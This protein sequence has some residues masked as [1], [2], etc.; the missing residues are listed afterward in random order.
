MRIW[1]DFVYSIQTP[2]VR[3]VVLYCSCLT[4][5]IQ[6]PLQLDDRGARHN[7]RA[8]DK[9]SRC[10]QVNWS[11][12]GFGRRTMIHA[13]LVRIPTA[14]WMMERLAEKKSASVEGLRKLY[15]FLG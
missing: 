12:H 14:G 13:I 10:G 8:E 7:T 1:L 3:S 15:H 11:P 9:Q 5:S 6:K 2:G 4:G